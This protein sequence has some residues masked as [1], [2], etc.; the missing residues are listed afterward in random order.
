MS[1]NALNQVHHFWQEKCA[2]KVI[3]CPPLRYSSPRGD[4]N[5]NPLSNPNLR[6]HQNTINNLK[7]Q[8]GC[9]HLCTHTLIV[10]SKYGGF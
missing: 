4:K 9:L 8:Q 5:S 6:D 3:N 1:R 7:L 2:I 10:L